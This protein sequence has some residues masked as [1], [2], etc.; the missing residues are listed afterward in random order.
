M[1]KKSAYDMTVGMDGKRAVENYTGLGNYSRYAVNILSAAYPSTT[2][3]L[4]APRQLENERL[5]PLLGRD[6]VQLVT[7][8]PTLEC[9]LTRALWRTVDLSTTLKADDVAVYHGLSNELPLTIKGVCPAVV[10]MHDI[11]YRRFPADY[12]AIDR[13]IYDFKYGRSARI[14]TRVIA[15]SECTRRD[16]IADYD[17]DPSKIDVIYQGADPVFTIRVDTAKRTEVRERY[18]LPQTFVLAVGTISPRKNQMLA[19]E[20]LSLLPK[21][22][23]LV[24]VGG[25]NKTYLAEIERRAAALGVADRVVRLHN[26]PLA[27]LPALYSLAAVSSY[28]SRYEGFGLPIVESLSSGTPVIACTGSCLEE[29]GGDGA[30]YI[31]PDDIRAFATEAERI[32]DDVIYHDRLARRGMVHVRRFSA[33]NFAKT[34]MATY[35]KA[36]LDFLM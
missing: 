2:F 17:I 10:T 19:V 15:I 22:V 16:I 7:A 8:K 32:I 29:A 35:N 18:H 5:R 27:D 4:Y 26:V 20:G 11:I 30:V 24:L 33:E 21:T 12:G 25:A 3:R 34:T 36:I 13:R 9:G 6:N 28:T 31:A 1:A 14:A 23:K